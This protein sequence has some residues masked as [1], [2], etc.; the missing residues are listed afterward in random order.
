MRPAANARSISRAQ[1]SNGAGDGNSL[2]QTFN[3][4]TLG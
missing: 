1:P 2:P 4:A 3:T